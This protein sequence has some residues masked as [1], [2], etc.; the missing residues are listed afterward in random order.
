MPER[1]YRGE[2]SREYDSE[3][4]R[5]R[6]R[7]R[8]DS[9][10]E[11]GG[12]YP[13]NR[14]NRDI[15][16][17][18]R[19]DRRGYSRYNE[20]RHRYDRRNDNR[21]HY[22]RDHNHR[23]EPDSRTDFDLHPNSDAH[24]GEEVEAT[25]SSEMRMRRR[26]E[27]NDNNNSQSTNRNELKREHSEDGESEHS[28][29]RRSSGDVRP[30]SR[31]NDGDNGLETNVR[32]RKN[33]SYYYESGTA[34]NYDHYSHEDIERSVPSNR[35]YS[36]HGEED[37]SDYDHGQGRAY[38]RR[39]RQDYESGEDEERITRP[40]KRRVSDASPPLEDQ[41]RHYRRSMASPRD[42]NPGENPSR[43]P[44]REGQSVLGCKNTSDDVVE[45]ESVVQRDKNEPD[46]YAAQ[47][48]EFNKNR[49]S[50]PMRIRDASHLDVEGRE[51]SDR[52]RGEPRQGFSSH[53]RGD[54][55]RVEYRNGFCPRGRG[56]PRHGLGARGRGETSRDGPHQNFGYRERDERRYGGGRPPFH[57]QFDRRQKDRFDN[58]RPNRGRSFG[59][60]SRGGFQGNPY[61]CDEPTVV[62]EIPFDENIVYDQ[63]IFRF[64]YVIHVEE[65]W[66]ESAPSDDIPEVYKL[67]EADMR[68]NGEYVGGD[69]TMKER[70]ASRRGEEKF[71][72]NGEGKTSEGNGDTLETNQ[73]SSG[74]GKKTSNEGTDKKIK[75]T[76]DHLSTGKAPKGDDPPKTNAQEDFNKNA[77]METELKHDEVKVGN[78]N[79]H[80]DRKAPE[81][82]A[83]SRADISMDIVE[84][85]DLN[86]NGGEDKNVSENRDLPT[87]GNWDENQRENGGRK[88]NENMD[89]DIPCDGKH[90]APME[91]EDLSGTDEKKNLDKKDD[92]SSGCASVGNPNPT[93]AGRAQ[94][95]NKA[96]DADAANNDSS[97][98]NVIVE[99]KEKK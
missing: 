25:G 15:Y 92:S 27:D 98:V 24:H 16:E 13:R 87:N 5:R 45:R 91:V 57:S 53:E 81:S 64:G 23:H 41:S 82:G 67:I 6:A 32:H 86:G 8:D 17:R 10:S 68:R 77:E 95:E 69:E 26:R 79:H 75:S 97:P 40:S 37:R 11:R 4:R 55:L 28:K 35:R 62:K 94:R 61:E 73:I 20:G 76:A 66:T 7:R 29:R 83:G 31:R 89:E 46:D 30:F 74:I 18:N 38:G 72:M 56:E 96:R 22:D 1:N 44:Q 59:G 36:R 99:K 48:A 93:D 39:S 60:A 51:H 88:G 80:K 65:T 9:P 34:H 50:R 21:L 14:D 2:R 19:D 90:R 3:D 78:G 54:L 49:N 70:E 47:V 85:E 12:Y 63:N 42:E 84:S 71:D 58:P 52:A 33:K 43:A